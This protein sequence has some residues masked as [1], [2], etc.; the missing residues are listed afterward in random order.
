MVEK[1]D[2]WSVFKATKSEPTFYSMSLVNE[3][4]DKV[5]HKTL[6][7]WHEDYFF[8]RL[9]YSFYNLNTYHVNMQTLNST[10]HVLIEYVDEGSDSIW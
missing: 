1:H 3:R 8:A 6:V 4:E 9:D 10:S 2:F 7:K 5:V